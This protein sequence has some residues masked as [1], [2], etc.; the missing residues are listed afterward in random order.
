VY[1]ECYR[2]ARR[3][4]EYFFGIAAERGCSITMSM[5]FHAFSGDPMVWCCRR[6]KTGR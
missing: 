4:S 6:G 5:D 3:E 1:Y 2:V